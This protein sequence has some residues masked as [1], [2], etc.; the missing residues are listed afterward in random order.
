VSEPLVGQIQ[1]GEPQL[2][3]MTSPVSDAFE[4]VRVEIARLR[5]GPDDVLVLRGDDLEGD[6]AA[7]LA[8]TFGCRVLLVASDVDV[9]VVSREEAERLQKKPLRPPLDPSNR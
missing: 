2:G 5:L 1:E 6:V 9:Q 4:P 3:G 7:E 8:E